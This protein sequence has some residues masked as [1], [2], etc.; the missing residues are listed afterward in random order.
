MHNILDE[1]E[2]G[3]IRPLTKEIAALGCLKY[4][5]WNCNVENCLS[6]FSRIRRNVNAVTYLYCI[7]SPIKFVHNCMGDWLSN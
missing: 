5:K 7:L 1:F 2:F 6:T 3:Q 4:P